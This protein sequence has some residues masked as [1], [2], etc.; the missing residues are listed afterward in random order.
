ME[1]RRG[2]YLGWLIEDCHGGYLVMVRGTQVRWVEAHGGLPWGW[3]ME[4]RRGGYLGWLMEDRHGDTWVGS[5]G[6]A[7]GVG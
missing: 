1:D 3:L 2:G 4:D 6:V 5:W 7:V